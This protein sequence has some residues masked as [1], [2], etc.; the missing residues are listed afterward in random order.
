MAANRKPAELKVLVWRK[1]FVPDPAY[2][3]NRIDCEALFQSRAQAADVAFDDARMRVE[4]DFPYVIS[5]RVTHRKP[6]RTG[7][8][9]LDSYKNTKPREKG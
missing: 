4:M 7:R 3:L 6:K 2:R 5:G 9:A 1:Q 8:A